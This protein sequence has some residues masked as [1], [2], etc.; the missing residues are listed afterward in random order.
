[1]TR[2]RRSLNTEEKRLWAHVTRGVKPMTG[3]ELPGEPEPAEEPKPALA[4]LAPPPLPLASRPAP[5]K[6]SPPPLAP[7]ERKTLQALRRGTRSVDAVIDLHGMRQAE[8]HMAL[9]G[10]LRRAQERDH[11]LVLVITGKGRSS[12]AGALF[13]ER[14]ILRRMVPHWLGLPELRA[15][16]LGFDEAVAHHGGSGALYVRLRRRR[17]AGSSA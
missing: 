9:M 2:R 16:V 1:M 14:G 11:G 5:K 3:K 13:E 10:F 8:A 15:L 17:G 4:S 6:P 7:V 12:S